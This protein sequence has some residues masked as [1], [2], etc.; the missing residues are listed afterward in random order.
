V[1]LCLKV[2]Y[3]GGLRYANDGRTDR[4]MRVLDY[5]VMN[6]IYP[7]AQQDDDNEDTQEIEV[8]NLVEDRLQRCLF[9]LTRQ[10]SSSNEKSGS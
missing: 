5:A 7:Q 8:S 4:E 10:R 9:D 6:G 1:V 2:A 3:L